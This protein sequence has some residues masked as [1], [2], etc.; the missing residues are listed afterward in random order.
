M[1]VLTRCQ[2][3][4]K[5]CQFVN[6]SVLWKRVSLCKLTLFAEPCKHS[7]ISPCFGYN[8]FL[9][10]VHI[11]TYGEEGAVHLSFPSSIKEL[12]SAS[13]NHNLDCR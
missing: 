11:L 12:S 5:V 3:T 1:R 9:L 2:C 10:F 6:T 8:C 4:H 7:F 13:A